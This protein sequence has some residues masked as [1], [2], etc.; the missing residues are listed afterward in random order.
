VRFPGESAPMTAQFSDGSVMEYD[1]PYSTPQAAK[2]WTCIDALAGSAAIPCG[3]EASRPH[4][5]C[6]EAIDKSGASPLVFATTSVR[7][8]DTPGGRLRWVAGLAAALER[9]YATGEWPDPPETQG[10]VSRT[11]Q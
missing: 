2:L 8:T 1:S 3:L 9:S 4:V 6:I 5:T 10:D 7:I 11:S